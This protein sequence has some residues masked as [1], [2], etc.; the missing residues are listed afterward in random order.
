M[1]PVEKS[2]VGYDEVVDREQAGADR[3]VD[4]FSDIERLAAI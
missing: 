1:T 4:L 3:R 2:R